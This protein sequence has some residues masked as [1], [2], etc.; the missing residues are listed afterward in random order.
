M[1]GIQ[2]LVKQP[3]WSEACEA[4]VISSLDLRFQTYGCPCASWEGNQ[5]SPGQDPGSQQPSV[6]ELPLAG[7]QA[8]KDN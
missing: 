7:S 2:V 1:K 3:P 4:P 8:A 5:G 6:W